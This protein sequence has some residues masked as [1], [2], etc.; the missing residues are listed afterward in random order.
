MEENITG[1]SLSKKV[2]KVLRK[3]WRWLFW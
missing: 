3:E 1:L 2:I